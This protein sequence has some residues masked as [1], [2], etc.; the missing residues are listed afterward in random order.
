MNR[1]QFRWIVLVLVA[2]IMGSG[3]V[4][5][6]EKSGG[7]DS[8]QEQKRGKRQLDLSEL[9]DREPGETFRLFALVIGVS[10]YQNLPPDKQL[11]FASVD[12]RAMRDFLVSERGG[13]RP[14]DVT[15]LIDKEA[16][17]HRILSKLEELKSL[18]GPRDLVLIYFAGHGFVK[19][20]Q[21][22]LLPSDAD[23]FE[24]LA[25]AIPMSLFN[26]T[27]RTMRA[28]GVV[29]IT[30][31]CH[32]GMIADLVDPSQGLVTNVGP[33]DFAEPSIRRGQSLFVFSAAGPMQASF[34][35]STLG[36]GV[37]THFL[38][39]GLE[40]EADRDADGVVRVRELY[41][42]VAVRVRD[43]A[44]R[45]GHVQVPEFH[46]VYDD[47]IPLAAVNELG[48]KLLRDW[49]E[50]EP[51]RAAFWAALEEGR[52]QAA[53]VLYDEMRERY[54]PDRIL[55]E[56]EELRTRLVT[57]AQAVI[58]QIPED[59][60]E[61]EKASAWFQKAHE[62]A[63][64]EIDK[65]VEARKT[66]V[67]AMARYFSGDLREAARNL[68]RTLSIIEEHRLYEPFLALRIARFYRGHESW[69]EAAQAY[70]L[71]VSGNPRGK[72]LV[73]YAEV[74]IKTND[75]KA[76]EE[77]LRRA[78][79]ADPEYV[80][81]L[82]LLARL[83]L[84]SESAEAKCSICGFPLDVKG[85]DDRVKEA[86][87]LAERAYRL[88]ENSDTT[89][90][91]GLASLL[92]GEPAQ[93]VELLRRVARDRLLDDSRRDDVLLHLSQAYVR[94]G[95]LN[96]AVSALWEAVERGSRQW[97]VYDELSVWLEK[98]GDVVSACDVAKKAVLVTTGDEEKGK[99]L[100]RV[101]EC[102]ERVGRLDEAI[103]TYRDALRF[104]RGSEAMALERHITV[105]SFRPR[106]QD[107]LDGGLSASPWRIVIPAGRDV[108]R[109]LA[110]LSIDFS[111]ED[112]ALALIFDACLRDAQARR[113]LVTFF[114]LYPELARRVISKGGRLNEELKLPSPDEKAISA[115]QEVWQFFGVKD[116]GGRREIEMKIFES[117]KHILEALGGSAEAVKRGEATAI[118]FPENGELP[119]FLGM[120]FWGK[121]LKEASK[122][123]PE[124]QLLVFLKD[125]SAM[126]LY[127]SL[128]MLPVEAARWI[129]DYVLTPETVSEVAAGM[130]FAAPYL[131]FATDP[132]LPA[133]M[134]L[135]FPGS[136]SVWERLLKARSPVEVVRELFRQE[137]GGILYLL[138]ALSAAG[139][140]GDFIARSSVLLDQF[141]R[142]VE[143]SPLPSVREPFDL[144]DLLSFLR[145]DGD[146]LRMR[147]Q[148]VETWL[149]S[150]HQRG[151]AIAVLLP[152]LGSVTA[153]RE[154][155]LVKQIAVLTQIE[156]ERPDWISERETIELIV[157][158]V[159]ARREPQLELAL[160]LRMSREQL[161]RYFA[162]VEQLELL[163]PPEK[164]QAAIRTFQSAFELLRVMARNGA[165]DSSHVV[166]LIDRF[167]ELDPGNNYFPLEVMAVVHR[168]LLRTPA[169][170]SGREVESALIA[171][172]AKSPPL[173]LP[174]RR[175]DDE[176]KANAEGSPRMV[177]YQYEVAKAGEERI[178]RLL[179][180]QRHTRL[181]TVVDAL[182]ALKA[183]ER[184]PSE[185]THLRQLR[186]ALES[187][188][189][190]DPPPMPR[191]KKSK[192][193]IARPLS[194][195]ELGERFATSADRSTL[196]EIRRRV[197]LFVGEALLGIVYAATLSGVGQNDVASDLVRRHDFNVEPW[198]NAEW[199]PARKAVRGSITR[200]GS[201][202]AQFES[203]SLGFGSTSS[204]A[205]AP[206][207]SSFVATALDSFRIAEHHLITDR[208]L[209]Y[210]ARTIDLGEDVLVLSTLRTPSDYVAQAIVERLENILLLRRA[211]V[212]RGWLD[213]GDPR[214]AIA[215]LTL[216]ELFY[217]GRRYFE[218]RLRAVPL[219]E[220]AKEPGSLGA[221]ARLVMENQSDAAG[222]QIP[223]V[224]EREIRQFGLTVMT[225][226]G[227]L[228]LDW[229]EDLEPYERSLVFSDARRL[230]ERVQDLK[231]ALA[232]AC[233]RQGCSAQLSLSPMLAQEVLRL[234]VAKQQGFHGGALSPEWNWRGLVSMIRDLAEQHL[235][236][237]IARLAGSPHAQL[238]PEVKWND[239]PTTQAPTAVGSK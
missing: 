220:L 193:P 50:S 143:K 10:E 121:I 108:L 37:F 20:G 218:A 200:L 99:R 46:V 56:R 129:F 25:T 40:G 67:M 139:P 180:G 232:R 221:L 215:E 65:V 54:P 52:L 101:G 165:L 2:V 104:L 32:S 110:G 156:R 146:R 107:H 80:P 163:S 168:D 147:S 16:T 197:G 237:I 169:W 171:L 41:G 85:R 73:E 23:R 189:E 68:N 117:R 162:L 15:L 208:A 149:G 34:E 12:A 217:I 55:K 98:R 29:I 123:K 77:Q 167:L 160:D 114:E 140:V 43:W 209:K 72:W 89:E 4:L 210:V 103:S 30:D 21:G 18:S 14:E 187:F 203:R 57:E 69:G 82:Q 173:M 185:L 93:A 202:V 137:R 157:K 100:R 231:L 229:R 44:E 132:R 8:F 142:L 235:P 75:L 236:E 166:E 136:D 5:P 28:R 179:E 109:R 204:S 151:S 118:T 58:D 19:Q 119:L 130:Y 144:M 74:L 227:L 116:K 206:P 71:A 87:R 186:T 53:S 154:I 182:D 133:H 36:H 1:V 62:L 6:R 198:G 201:V 105:L 239:A 42:Y 148:A 205:Q 134:R 207:L 51:V 135:S 223:A 90:I 38:L 138:A 79:D 181:A 213:R 64:D 35:D 66:Y 113:R 86:V 195:K 216:S 131:R 228:R 78:V 126:R 47:S 124:E 94:I 24:L 225:R 97:P 174:S 115:V 175:A 31:A 39:R 191:G 164:R 76:A 92:T 158:Q 170:A 88:E 125:Q 192:Q 22:F 63:G 234:L 176:T 3:E 84:Q 120:E 95:D 48:R 111:N 33:K 112:R 81:A 155:P 212:V 150:Q 211:L 102:L 214:R 230:A 226:A 183:L 141:Y 60:T 238:L 152:R 11:K 13:F 91:Y 17:R 177:L 26:D 145:V 161:H 83:L 122:A 49:F 128:S 184:E 222:S 219:S 159:S 27:V 190:P 96:R 196:E 172:L 59:P 199:D 194:L 178:R 9:H 70:R 224:L 153:G 45:K 7:F 127:V 61:W 106:R 233:Y 188:I